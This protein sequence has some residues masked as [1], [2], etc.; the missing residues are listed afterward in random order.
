[1]VDEG[2]NWQTDKEGSEYRNL[3]DVIDNK[4]VPKVLSVAQPPDW[5]GEVVRGAAPDADNCNTIDDLR[6]WCSVIGTRY[7]CH[8]VS[9]LD[10]STEYLVQMSLST[11]GLGVRAILPVEDDD[12]HYFI[13]VSTMTSTVR[14]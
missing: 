14:E 13:G 10:Q 1:M 8:A 2:Q 12:L 11:S 9:T 3:V 4:I 7:E 5:N 6:R